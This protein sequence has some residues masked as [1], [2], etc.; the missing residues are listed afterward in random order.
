MPEL[1][2]EADEVAE[3][4]PFLSRADEPFE[5]P[6]PGAAAEERAA[7]ALEYIAYQLFHLRL[8]LGEIA[9]AA[10]APNGMARR[11]RRP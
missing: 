2:D 8:A 5:P 6:P 9:A 11:R 10:E 7:R 1:A 3:G 4:R